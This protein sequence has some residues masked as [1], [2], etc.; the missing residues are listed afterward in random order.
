MPWCSV[1]SGVKIQE[2]TVAAV[3]TTQPQMEDPQSVT[4]SP[5]SQPAVRQVNTADGTVTQV[6]IIIVC[7]TTDK[8]P[9]LEP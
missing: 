8:R 3:P 7:I 1:R 9:T 5:L 2:R 6:S 4:T